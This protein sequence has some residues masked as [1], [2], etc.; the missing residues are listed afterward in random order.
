MFGGL[1]LV[2]LVVTPVWFVSLDTP[3]VVQDR[4]ARLLQTARE[5]AV[6]DDLSQNDRT[7]LLPT[8]QGE[9]TFNPPP[10]STWLVM[11]A[12]RGLDVHNAPPE[13]LINRARLLSLL[14]G[15]LAL[16]GTYWAGKSIGDIRTARLAALA[17]GTTLLFVDQVRTACAET[18]MLAWVT[19]AVA[20]G[21]WAMRPLREI[22]WVGRRVMGW[23][24]CGLSLASATLT[25]GIGLAV[26][27][28]L[29]PLFAAI[30]LTPRRRIG[31][32]IGM[33]FAVILGLIGAAPWFLYVLNE[34]PATEPS[35]FFQ[36]LLPPRDLFLITWSHA[37]VLV[38]LSPWVVW[39]MGAMFQ[40]FIRADHER[41]RQLL[42]A[43]FWFLMVF[44]FVS[45]PASRSVRELWPL[46]PAAGLL[47][48]QLW[49]FHAQLS[50]ERREDPGVD[51]L[52]VPHW[53]M[54]G[55][56]AGVGGALLAFQDDLVA[57]DWLQQPL[58]EG[59]NKT[60]ALALGAVLLVVAAIGAR[61]HFK[62]MPRAAAYT[63]VAW[64]LI[65]LAACLPAYSQQAAM[66]FRYADQASKLAQTLP[67]DAVVFHL[68][69][70]VPRQDSIA[71]VLLF[72]ARRTVQPLSL[73]QL[74]TAVLQTS[75]AW[76]LC[77]PGSSGHAL[78]LEAGFVP[79]MEF[80]D[81]RAHRILMHRV[82]GVTAVG[83]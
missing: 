68:R 76:V 27:Y 59:F 7:W 34:L 28:V 56:T 57:A 13:T 10:L 60:V 62:W 51:W 15:L 78:L 33:I 5:T 74:P 82:S 48:G 32:F 11:I 72:Y 24:L 23:F 20:A 53:L 29:P 31:N 12:W 64:I 83:L 26:L 63:T 25:M 77:S 67:Q 66:K 1:A 47:V 14:M 55:L 46:L 75:T 35:V 58:L 44:I 19:L 38:V 21:L 30:L 69:S 52:R 18:H 45:I 42:I 41:R 22:N 8:Y 3:Q 81:G 16:A 2:L 6:R 39:L 70:G 54:L 80:E 17:L 73:D 36:S 9:Y 65:A 37:R 40:P 49:S 79:A 4:E 61:W 43:W 71:P 50:S